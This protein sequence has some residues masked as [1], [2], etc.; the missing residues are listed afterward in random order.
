MQDISMCVK[1]ILLGRLICNCRQFNYYLILFP[2]QD[3]SLLSLCFF[4]S[5]I[6]FRFTDPG[7][8]HRIPFFS[9]VTRYPHIMTVNFEEKPETTD[10]DNAVL[11]R[12][13]DTYAGAIPVSFRFRLPLMPEQVRKMH[14]EFRS[15]GNLR[16]TLLSRNAK[17]VTVITATQYTGEEFFQGG[18][19][20]FKRQLSDQLNN[21]IYE[22][23]RKQV[24]VSQ[25]DLAP[26]GSGQGDS[27]KLQIT[28]QL[29]WKTV[30][31]LDDHGKER[32]SENPL[33]QYGIEVTQVLLSDPRPESALEK[34]LLDKKRLVADRIK[35]VQ[36]QETSRAQAKT[37]QMKKEIQRT[38]EVQDAQRLKELAVIGQQKEVEVAKQIAEREIVEQ[39]KKLN[40]SRIE[41]E[42]ELNVAQS[43]LNIQKANSDSSVYEARAIAAKGKAEA[44]VLAAMYKAK[45]QNKEVY[46]AEVQRDIAKSIYGNLKDFK[47]EMPQNYIGG[48]GSDSGKLTSN[49][50]V[51]TGLAAL[52]MMDQS[53][54]VAKG[55]GGFPFFGGLQK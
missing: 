55:G 50:D 22:T 28:Q 2:V 11:V 16:S 45:A 54:A 32:R 5:I 49:L 13:A 53:K 48:G 23:V 51:I 27:Q 20:Q 6:K 24:E 30:P 44:E 10:S 4:V 34:L 7:L 36:E 17:N 29:V 39:E 25:T 46:M 31:I 40:I 21:G 26:V 9:S 35:A 33:S 14:K 19:N 1:T 41:K 37:E 52:G 47:V 42:K 12:F 43:N 3:I 18:L 15:D 8:H 38:K